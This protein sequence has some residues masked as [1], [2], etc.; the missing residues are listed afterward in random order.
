M[1]DDRHHNLLAQI[2]YM[3]YEQ[4]LT[5]NE[6]A[7][8]LGLS[9]VKIY[10]LLK[11]AKAERVVEIKINWPLERDPELEKL[12]IQTFGL[13]DALVLKTISQDHVSILSQ[14]GQLTAYYLE[15]ILADGSTL[16]ICL[17]RS[18]YE[19]INAISPN[20]Q[21]KIRVA[22]A[23]GSMP[24]AM[25]EL[26][27]A[28]LARQLA[29][30]LGGEVLYLSSPLIAD[31]P[32][33]AVVLRR[34][35]EIERTLAAARQADVALVGIGNLDSA[36]S[37]FVKAGVITAAELAALRDDGAV[38][39]VAGQI[40]TI[41]GEL[42]PCEYN[43]LLVG[44]TFDELCQIP[45]TIAVAGGQEKTTAIW[46]GLRTCAIK[47]FCT[48]DQTAREVLNLHRG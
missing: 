46:G 43:R 8:Q 24:F 3:Y 2:A 4:E 13:K 18:T 9:R 33:A 7:A 38:G 36:T 29:Q 44:I 47:V 6:I 21:A 35:R 48:D 39:D 16:A 27:S 40:F 15:Q 17:G 19:V 20:F 26:D 22:Q 11:Q 34:Q 45:T 28:A 1:P 12:L 31:S 42:H 32:E 23:M 14:L 30:K 25:Q 37:G 41:T 5:Q 10:R